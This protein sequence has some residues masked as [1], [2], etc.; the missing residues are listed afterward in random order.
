MFLLCSLKGIFMNRII[1]SDGVQNYKSQ[2]GNTT[3]SSISEVTCEINRLLTKISSSYFACGSQ[4]VVFIADDEQISLSVLKSK[5]K[6][7][8]SSENVEQRSLAYTVS[9]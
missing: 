8:L 9:F 1:F 5:L 6:D 2:Y 3:S 7:Y 4:E